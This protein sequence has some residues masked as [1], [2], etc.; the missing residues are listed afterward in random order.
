MYT[1]ELKISSFGRTNTAR[2][3]SPSTARGLPSARIFIRVSRRLSTLFSVLPAAPRLDT[4]GVTRQ[5]R[6]TR[7]ETRNAVV[8]FRSND[9]TLVPSVMLVK[10]SSLSFFYLSISLSFFLPQALYFMFQRFFSFL[11]SCFW[12][13]APECRESADTVAFYL[14]LEN[15]STKDVVLEGM[16]K[17]LLSL[18]EP[19]YGQR[20][21]ERCAWRS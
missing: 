1:N 12:Y 14:L 5:H 9:A 3:G 8:K 16:R 20:N 6:K 19:A 15:S 18:W 21:C 2:G 11:W 13:F 17:V 7:R 4:I 10:L